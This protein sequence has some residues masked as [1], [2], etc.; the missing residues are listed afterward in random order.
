[1][2]FCGE[3]ILCSCRSA[4]RT[5]QMLGSAVAPR[6]TAIQV[7]SGDQVASMSRVLSEVS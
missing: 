7:P 4:T 5:A 6:E 2:Y 1:M 3:E